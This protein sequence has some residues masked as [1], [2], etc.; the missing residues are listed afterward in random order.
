MRVAATCCA[1]LTLAAC[2]PLGEAGYVEIRMAPSSSSLALHLD[3]TKIPP[4]KNGISVLRQR[5]GTAKLQVAGAGQMLLLCDV[6]VKKNR[7]TTVTV[8]ALERPPRCQCNDRMASQAGS[9]K[10]CAA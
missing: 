7:I 10:V 6:V 3:A 9:S 4:V 5:V 8:S 1:A 2:Q